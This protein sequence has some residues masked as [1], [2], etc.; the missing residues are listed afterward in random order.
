REERDRRRGVEPVVAEAEVEDRDKRDQHRRP[1]RW[2]PKR[3]DEDRCEAEDGGAE[4]VERDRPS[5][6]EQ[7][8][9]PSEAR[10]RQRKRQSRGPRAAP[11]GWSARRER[12]EA[13]TREQ[14]RSERTND[15]NLLGV[16]QQPERRHDA[17]E[18]PIERRMRAHGQDRAR[19]S[20][21]P[22]QQAASVE[23]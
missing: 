3:E 17:H 15:E 2:Q 16:A 22:G 13:E 11:R 6:G 9:G 18:R 5:A 12:L 23:P 10:G 14:P 4:R 1:D 21:G 8:Q 20:E 19:R 7:R